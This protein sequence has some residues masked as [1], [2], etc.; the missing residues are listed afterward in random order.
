[1]NRDHVRYIAFA[2]LA[3]A[4]ITVLDSSQLEPRRYMADVRRQW[5][6]RMWV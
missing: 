2:I 1:M 5:N 6:W 3:I 4:A